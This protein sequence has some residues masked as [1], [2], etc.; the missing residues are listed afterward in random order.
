MPSFASC[1]HQLSAT[2]REGVGEGSISSSMFIC[3]YTMPLRTR[4][5]YA[6][7]G[8]ISPLSSPVNRRQWQQLPDMFV[9]ITIAGIVLGTSCH[10]LP[11]SRVARG[12]ILHSAECPFLCCMAQSCWAPAAAACCLPDLWR[13][14]SF[15]SAEHS[16]PQWPV[17]WAWPTLGFSWKPKA[18]HGG[19]STVTGDG[20]M[21]THAQQTL[22]ILPGL[23]ALLSI[24]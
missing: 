1:L 9:G 21:L 16:P 12:L 18:E 22:N 4:E 13:L 15:P 24:L 10:C 11:F 6:A 2:G 23:S 7:E 14:L 3:L 17:C 8:R 20:G 19:L 5:R